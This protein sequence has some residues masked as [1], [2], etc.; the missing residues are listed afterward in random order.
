MAASRYQS[1]LSR[2]WPV[3]IPAIAALFCAAISIYLFLQIDQ[4]RKHLLKDGVFEFNFVQQV[5]HNFDALALALVD[6]GYATSEQES[7]E[8][9]NDYISRYD[10]LY[11]SLISVG[12]RWHGE[13]EEL[14]ETATLNDKAV[15]F[16]YRYEHMMSP[17]QTINLTDRRRIIKEAHELS[18]GV[19]NLGL[20]LFENKTMA[21]DNISSR[22]D[23][24]YNAFWLFSA[25]F[26]LSSLL[27]VTL[28]VYMSRRASSLS[29]KSQQTQS[30]LMLA[31]DE[32]SSGDI[33]RKAQNRFM[34]AASHDLRQP[35][36]AL[37]LYLG[38]LGSHVKSQQGKRILN[39]IN[40]SAEALSQLLNSMLDLSKLDAGVVDVNLNEVDLDRLF[41]R[42]SQD[43]LPVAS[44][45]GLELHVIYSGL[46]VHSDQVLL[47]RILR[48]LIS[49]AL[50][51]THRGS[52]TLRAKTDAQGLVEIDV[53]DTG[54][55]I[56]AKDHVLIFD[57]YY[58]LHNPE[59]DRSKGL[60]L[61][62]SIVRRLTKLLDIELF[63]DSQLHK[64][65]CFTLKVAAGQAEL[66]QGSPLHLNVR[67]DKSS[68]KGLSI[69]FIDDE[70][71]VRDGMSSLLMEND[72]DV[73]LAD[74][75]DSAIKQLLELD[76]VPE[77]IIA[78]YRLRDGKTGVEA[79]ERVRDEVN[80]DVPAMII[81]GDTSPARLRE[82]KS[83]GFYL[84]HKPVLA[85]QLLDAVMMLVRNYA[86]AEFEVS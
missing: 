68:L 4:S 61:G 79:I 82:A 55:G 50:N 84:L 9:K 85:D 49:N 65:T 18:T 41:N 14:P 1:T 69:L 48:N 51:Y 36:H 6:Y 45:K 72:C 39:N 46:L 5:D 76:W 28:I 63:I 42:L 57:E 31:L 16:L 56:E 53:L 47:E 74:G 73:V 70:L 15:E 22:M 13:L 27:A 67:W 19:Y 80:A 77:L 64:G 60:G 30:R 12:D 75:E 66:A 20:I 32:L 26:I 23:D 37:G 83:S 8:L 54:L 3:T 21:R 35:L 34:A 43:F 38:A 17:S 33:E 25:T 81:T 2:L 7:I 11:S 52:V 71:D 29:E 24:L 58:Q 40:H 59:R 86:S 44:H 62:L 78:D 10:V